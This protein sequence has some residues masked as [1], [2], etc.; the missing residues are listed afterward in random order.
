MKSYKN[1]MLIG[2]LEKAIDSMC[3]GIG[4]RR[5]KI[6]LNSMVKSGDDV[7]YLFVIYYLWFAWKWQEVIW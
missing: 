1:L 5:V 2:S 3:I 7:A 4:T 6:F